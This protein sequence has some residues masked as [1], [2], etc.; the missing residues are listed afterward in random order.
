M[1]TKDEAIK[2]AETM[3]EW[4]EGK[5]CNNC[6]FGIK[7]DEG[8]YRCYFALGGFPARWKIPKACRWTKT[9]L[10]LA[11]ALK[12]A[13]ADKVFRTRT[14]EFVLWQSVEQRGYL[15]VGAFDALSKDE[16]VALDTIIQ[17]AKEG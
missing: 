17:E 3:K 12:K 4:C 15:P 14:G 1:I 7:E 10:E 13:G 6:P 16:V 5:L 9:D 2:A 11:K 8:E